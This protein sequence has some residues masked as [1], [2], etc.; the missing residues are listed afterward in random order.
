MSKPKK[1]GLE[2]VQK[3]Q[4]DSSKLLPTFSSHARAHARPY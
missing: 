3:R 1:Y 2:S 4:D